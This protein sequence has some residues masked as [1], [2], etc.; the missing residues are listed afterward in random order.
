MLC[1]VVEDGEMKLEE[2][3]VVEES[4]EGISEEVSGEG[5]EVVE[6]AKEIAEGGEIAAKILESTPNPPPPTN[7]EPPPDDEFNSNPQVNIEDMKGE[8]TLAIPSH[9]PLN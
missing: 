7:P 6:M 4:K 9:N 8:K 3:N 5:G 2:S 1:N